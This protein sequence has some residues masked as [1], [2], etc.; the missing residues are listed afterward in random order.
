M[1]AAAIVFGIAFVASPVAWSQNAVNSATV[2]PP[3]TVTDPNNANNSA[4]DSDAITRTANLSLTKTA[5]PSPVVVGQLLTYILTVSNAGPSAIAAANTFSIVESLPAGL[6]GCSFTPS[7]GTF[8][9]GTIASGATGTGT[10]TGVAIPSGGNATLTIACTVSGAAAASITNTATVIP[11]TGV[12][13]PDCSGTPV[14]CAGGN[15]GSVTTPVNRPVLTLTKTA[16]AASF[17]VGVPASYTLSVQNTGT[18]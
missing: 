12:T 7:S 2:T 18:A 1:I 5:S 13:D 9:V 6:T 16:S 14:T 3:A 4:T 8:T 15:T 11:P 17:T 10:W